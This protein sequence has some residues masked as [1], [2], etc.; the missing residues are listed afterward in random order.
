MIRLFLIL[1]LV[2]IPAA[3]YGQCAGCGFGGGGYSSG[4][5]GGYT[6][7]VASYGPSANYGSGYGSAGGTASYGCAG[8]VGG[9]SYYAAPRAYVRRSYRYATPVVYTYPSHGWYAVSW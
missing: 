5:G 8:G 4:Y 3:A 2:L 6:S 1:A 7:S 9:V